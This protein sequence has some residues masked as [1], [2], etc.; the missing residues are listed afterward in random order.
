MRD[1]RRFALHDVRVGGEPVGGATIDS[2]HDATHARWCARLMMPEALATGDG[3]LEGTTTDGRRVRGSVR[4]G[5]T[6]AGTRRAWVLAEL[7]GL[8]PLDVV[9]DEA[10]AAPR[11][12]TAG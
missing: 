2:W 4:V 8:G 11:T 12:S 6:Q 7:H 5:S 3:V 1:H 9:P 10:E